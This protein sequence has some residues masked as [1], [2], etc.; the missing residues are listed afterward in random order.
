MKLQMYQR[1]A[2]SFL[3]IG[4]SLGMYGCI[5]SLKVNTP[6]TPFDLGVLNLPVNEG[7]ID[8]RAE[9]IIIPEVIV[10]GE[11]DSLNMVYRYTNVLVNEPK[12]YLSSR[13]AQH[14]SEMFRFRAQQYLG[15]GY[16]V[17]LTSELE[18]DHSW[19]LRLV[20]EDFSQH[21]TSDQDSTGVVQVRATLMYGG[22][23]ID[24]RL[25]RSQVAAQ[26]NASGA[27]AAITTATDE[28]LSDLYGWIGRHI[29]N[30][31]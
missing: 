22:S 27:A 6:P 24:Q 26:P 14:P 4:L 23:F 1:I 17:T 12:F 2:R 11:I 19:V 8:A 3:L 18:S 15:I 16:P 31:P 9:V 20:V 10:S 28:V 25:F 30:Q 21:F 7:G 5:P 29:Q 13:W